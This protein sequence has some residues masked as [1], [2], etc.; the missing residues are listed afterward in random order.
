MHPFFGETLHMLA[1]FNMQITVRI[2]SAIVQYSF[3]GGKHS[4][5]P[6][7]H[8]KGQNYVCPMPSTLRKL[9]KVAVNLTQK[10]AVC[11]TLK[12]VTTAS[13]AGSIVRNR[14]QIAA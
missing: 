6:C 14:Q 2:Y 11:E 8:G 13:S 10:F 7:P 1:I 12:N 9:R 5:I 3:D 4:V